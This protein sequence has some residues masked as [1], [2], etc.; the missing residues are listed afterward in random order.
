MHRILFLLPFI[1]TSSVPAAEA[2]NSNKAP[3][4][5]PQHAPTGELQREQMKKLDFLVGEW[6]GDGWIML[7]PNQKNTL[8]ET[9]SVQ[10]KL[11]GVIVL[12]EGVGKRT[13]SDEV[14]HNALAVVAYDQ[15]HQRFRFSAYHSRGDFADAEAKIGDKTLEWGFDLPNMGTIRYAIKLNAEG[16]WFEIGE[17]SADGKTWQKFFEMTLSR[18]K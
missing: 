4:A 5:P 15:H 14:T 12:I 16:K 8:T 7:G 3:S 10:G 1:L 18:R 13:G 9:E 2:D 17:R 11:G 6:K